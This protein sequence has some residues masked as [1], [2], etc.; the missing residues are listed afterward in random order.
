VTARY[1]PGLDGL[2][3]VAVAGVLAFHG[4]LPHCQG[5]F[6]G[7]SSF[8]TLSGFLITS[9]LVR[10]YAER[11]RIR[12]PRFWARR[13]R[14]LMPA[15]I[16]TLLGV[17]TAA[18]VTDASQLWP[19]RGDAFAALFYYANWHFLI[20]GRSYAALFFEPSP[21][22]HFWSLSI[23]EQFYIFYPLL[24]LGW[25][26]WSGGS[27]RSLA[28]VLG[29]LTLGSM[30]SMAALV[31]NDLS[32]VYYG[33]DTRAA[34]LLVGALLALWLPGDRPLVGTA[35]RLV[36]W[37]AL[38][39]LLGLLGLWSLAYEQDTWVYRGGIQ[40]N[41]ILTAV[42]IL[43]ATR[44]GPASALLSWAPLRWLGRVSYGVY[45]FHWPVFLWLDASATGLTGAPLF[46]LRVAVVLGLAELSYRFIEQPIRSGRRL[47]GTHTWIAAAVGAA[48][49]SAVL[50]TVTRDAIPPIFARGEVG[51]R[52][53][54]RARPEAL[55]VMVVGDSVADS[56]AVG[57]SQWGIR[58][59]DISVL[60][61]SRSNCGITRTGERRSFAG[62]IPNPCPDWSKSWPERLERYEPRIVLVLTSLWDLIDQRGPQGG[63]RAPGHPVYDENAIAEFREA[64]EVLSARGAHVVWLTAPCVDPA[65]AQRILN[66]SGTELARVIHLNRVL[67]PE[68]RARTA[69]ELRVLDLFGRVCP[70]GRFLSD[71]G[72]ASDRSDGIHFSLEGSLA[73]AEWLG[74]E[75]QAIAARTRATE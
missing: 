42:V 13:F 69:G 37:L 56:L 4:Q 64:Y 17:A 12:L 58:T 41:A 33:T 51:D 11:G 59:G 2:R 35:R 73:V 31:G 43:G 55:R 38:L 19:L 60:N 40:L 25:L 52:R 34:E 72:G 16:V 57:L 47:A 49:V 61:L 67:L 54:S 71:A 3:A 1:Y 28:I 22:Q 30:A 15:A 62:R 65:V 46:A 29:V 70:H 5:G 23:E 9:L 50:V 44:A 18:F 21:V 75:L 45:L 53:P 20:S 8:F 68:L 32:R 14:R 66:G 63:R 7:V 36:P 26:R 10:E 48:C 39:S 27:A 24:T 74:P 6:L